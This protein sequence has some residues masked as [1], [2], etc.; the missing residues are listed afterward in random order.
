MINPEVKAIVQQK[1]TL[2]IPSW[3]NA[4]FKKVIDRNS[5]FEYISLLLT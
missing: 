5:R 4:A 3:K 2:F 1:K